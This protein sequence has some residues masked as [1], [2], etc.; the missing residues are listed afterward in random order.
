MSSFIKKLSYCLPLLVMF[1]ACG[2]SDDGPDA[3]TEEELLDQ[4]FIAGELRAVNRNTIDWEAL[5]QLV[6][7][8]Y[9]TE[10]YDEAVVV[11][12]NGL[13]ENQ[14]FYSRQNGQ[15][16]FGSDIGCTSSGYTFADLDDDIG[17][18]QMRAFVGDIQEA[19]LFSGDRH[20][21]ARIQ[22]G[23]NNKGWVVDLTTTNGGLLTPLLA[24]LG[25]FYDQETLGYFINDDEE[26]AFGYTDGRAYI[27]NAS[28]SETRV[29]DPYTLMNPDAKLVV[30]IDLV[31]S[32]AGEAV[33]V[34]LKD[35]PNTLVLGRPTCGISS[36][37]QSFPLSNGDAITLV[38]HFLG[39][40]DKQTFTSRLQPDVQVG[41]TN[42]LISRIN[43]FL[44]D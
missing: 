20:N 35:R 23:P 2:G 3:S 42:E 44:T 31:T 30:V 40:R 11:Y 10:G 6:L 33:V 43:D 28:E 21:R 7:D 9:N 15:T 38:T 39:D 41:N 18:I 17:Y 1:L 12:L 27:R 13:G 4:L 22:D 34:A 26:I 37:T 14:S 19:T 32:G 25:M 16:I 5:R 24:S 29:V 36:V 8:T